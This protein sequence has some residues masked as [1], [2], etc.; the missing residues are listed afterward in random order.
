MPI[1]EDIVNPKWNPYNFK[2]IWSGDN[3]FTV[4]GGKLYRYSFDGQRTVNK[5][6]QNPYLYTRGPS[7]VI[8]KDYWRQ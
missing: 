4:G 5:I 6:I 1:H 2:I 7:M 8:M 3:L